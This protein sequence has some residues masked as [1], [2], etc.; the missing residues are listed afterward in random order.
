MN[1]AQRRATVKRLSLEDDELTIDKVMV[2][3][4]NGQNVTMDM[5]RVELVDKDTKEP[6][7]KR[8]A[9]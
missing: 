8:E 2:Y 1:R 6:I 7:F 5:N 4:T 3:F 9:L